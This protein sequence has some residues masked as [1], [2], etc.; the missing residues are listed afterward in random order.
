MRINGF[1]NRYD[2]STDGIIY[3]KAKKRNLKPH[4]SKSL[5]YEMVTLISDD[6]IKKV[7][8]LHQLMAE[9][10]IDSSYKSKGLVVDHIDRNRANNKIN[11]LRIVS[12]S[13][14]L[15]NNDSKNYYYCKQRNKFTVQITRG[16]VRYGKRFSEEQ[17]A[18]EYVRMIT[19]KL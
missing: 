7:C 4:V 2:I 19:N 8:Y 11:N 16:G 14:N 9:T 6:G 12:Q 17:D 10:F 3:S 5:G 13:E 1:N 15:E 18:I